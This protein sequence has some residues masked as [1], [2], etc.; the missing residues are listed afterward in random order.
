MRERV[1][2]IAA[3]PDDELLGCG[4]TIALHA[5][6]GD[7]VFLIIAAE[8]ATSRGEISQI[9]KFKNETNF[10]K[11]CSQ[12][13][14]DLIGIKDLKM[15]EL[16]DNR[17]DSLDRLEL[18]KLIESHLNK[19]KPTIVYTHH[20]GDLNVDHRRLHE[21]VLTACRPKPQFFVKRILSFETLSSTEWQSHGN[22]SFFQPNWYVD[23]SSVLEVKIKA[24]SFYNSEICDWPHPRSIEAVKYLAKYRGSQVGKD[25]AEGFFLLRYLE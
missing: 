5:L 10:L 25:A 6:K 15:L 16:P 8:G 17:M 7:D 18:I 21:A 19:I 13:A 9:D 23:I 4:G 14:A 20:S 22:G 12:K 2:V 1:L 3:H 11:E 24:L